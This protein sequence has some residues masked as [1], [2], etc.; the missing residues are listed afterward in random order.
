MRWLR[1]K[2]SKGLGLAY[3]RHRAEAIDVAFQSSPPDLEP[4]SKYHHQ[5][6]RPQLLRLKQ[7]L[8]H[9]L[10]LLRVPALRLPAAALLQQVRHS[11][12]TPIHPLWEYL[13][14]Q[15]RNR[16]TLIHLRRRRLWAW[17][18]QKR[19]RIALVVLLYL[20]IWSVPLLIGEALLTVFAILPLVLVPPVGYLVYWLV[21]QEFHA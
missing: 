5:P 2:N 6:E 21:W 14:E 15:Q 11:E 8:M 10:P 16:R 17:L 19:Q 20:L 4:A 3:L 12:A 7:W 1:R 13:P 9:R 18:K